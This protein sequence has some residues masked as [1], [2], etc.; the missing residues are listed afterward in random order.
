[1]NLAHEIL[2]TLGVLLLLGLAAVFVRVMMY[3]TLSDSKC[4]RCPLLEQCTLSH[5]PMCDLTQGK[6]KKDE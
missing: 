3:L 1:M 4:L 6:D 2:M 5:M